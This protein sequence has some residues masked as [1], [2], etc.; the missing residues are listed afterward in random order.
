[1]LW[2]QSE[3]KSNLLLLLLY[4]IW[5]KQKSDIHYFK[6]VLK[7]LKLEIIKKVKGN[8]MDSEG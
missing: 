7:N 2:Q 6:N 3:I 1:M 4:F 8:L 5:C